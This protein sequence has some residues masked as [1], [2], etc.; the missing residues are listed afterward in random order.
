[1][2]VA[3]AF[4]ACGKPPTQP[5]PPSPSPPRPTLTAIRLDGPMTLARGE[6][7]RLTAIAEWSDGSSQDVTASA[8]WQIGPSGP[9]PNHTGSN[10]LQFLGRG[11]VQAIGFGEASIRVRIP[12]ESHDVATSP[13]LS[14]LVLDP[15]TF[16]ISGAVLS[17]GLPE[18]ATIEIIS[19]TGSGQRTA[20]G[21]AS[22]VGQ[23][24]LYG[25]AGSV[26]LSV[27]ATGF[28]GQVRRLVV[29]GNTT[30]DFDLN[31][32]VPST[33][34]SGSWVARLSASPACRAK[35]P[36][37][38]WEREFNVDITQQGTRV[39]IARTSP[40]FREVCAVDDSPFKEDGRIF[41]ETLSFGITGD[42]YHGDHSYP[43]LFD[44][45]S[46]TEWLG[47][48][49]AVEATVSGDTIRG[50]MDSTHGAFDVYK[51]QISSDPPSG[52]FLTAICHAADHVLT[53]R[54]R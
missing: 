25:A 23:Y 43:C 44:R 48:S 4:T 51:T 36:E 13:T 2:A 34:I 15:G 49:G 20:T 37:A 26:E 33:D 54:R 35:T 30:S 10:V 45:L 47:I 41:G 8:S 40:T 5:T 53:L 24:A 42:T 17:A 16:R 27:S 22:Y 28:N 12:S 21:F 6:T 32:L 9:D 18:S 14:V 46:P 7:G 50:A 39:T 19:G 29:T 31:P 3:V 11:M 1:M 38:G 52:N